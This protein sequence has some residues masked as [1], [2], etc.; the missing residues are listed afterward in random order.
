MEFAIAHDEE[1]SV[2]I[3]NG[4][5][6][7]QVPKKLTEAEL[8]EAIAEARKQRAKQRAAEESEDEWD[9]P[10]GEAPRA[11]RPKPRGD[12]GP[13]AIRAPD[14]NI[15][16]VHDEEEQGRGQGR[17][18][19]MAAWGRALDGGNPALDAPASDGDGYSD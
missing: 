18:R 7:R 19:G 11:S 3:C 17:A 13:M 16:I 8:R 6:H 10:L 9:I 1:R 14:G 15:Y 5:N 12:D 2:T 4:N